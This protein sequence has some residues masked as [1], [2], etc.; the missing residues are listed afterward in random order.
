MKS[1]I[2]V[3]ERPRPIWQIPIAAFFFTFATILLLSLVY[4]LKFTEDDLKIAIKKLYS[5]MWLVSIGTGFCYKKQIQVDVKNSKFKPTIVIGPV[6]LGQWNTINNY[7]YVSVFLQPLV[8]GTTTFEVNLWYDHNKHF[9][10]YYVNDYTEAFLIG[11]ELSEQLNIDLLD[12]TV[13]ND[14]KWVDKDEWKA[15]IHEDTSK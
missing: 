10:L 13:P 9:E 6:K 4:D 14:F 1:N 3:S 7:K 8:D 11:Y 12:A 15:K 5:V 2:I